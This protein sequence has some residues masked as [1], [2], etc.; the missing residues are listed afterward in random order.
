MLNRPHIF[1]SLYS[2]S[3][4]RLRNHHH[5]DSCRG[6]RCGGGGRGHRMRCPGTLVPLDWGSGA[7]AGGTVP[8]VLW[9]RETRR[10]ISVCGLRN[11]RNTFLSLHWAFTLYSQSMNYELL[12]FKGSVKVLRTQGASFMSL[13]RGILRVRRD[14]ENPL[15]CTLKTHLMFKASPWVFMHCLQ[16]P[17]NT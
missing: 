7:A 15:V 13:Y 17:M 5:S 12:A 8:A 1:I 11:L 3:L 2:S 9:G 10:K 14:I 16:C 4:H 6:A